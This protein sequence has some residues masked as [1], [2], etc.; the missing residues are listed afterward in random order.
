MSGYLDASLLVALLN[1]EEGSEAAW[2]YMDTTDVDL[3]VSDFAIGEVSSAVSRL[4][5]MGRIEL[6][7]G[8]SRLASFD[9]WIASA[10]HSI[11]TD[12]ADVRLAVEQVR[13]FGLMIR[14]PDAIHL[15]AAQRRS[16][17]LVTL[18][19]RLGMAAESL[20]LSLIVP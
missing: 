18:D 10:A 8:K 2:R 16:M 7:E 14:M 9:R 12:E 20:G 1:S 4:V 13:Q 11:R 17:T 5:R 6:D 19:R 15:A 3:V